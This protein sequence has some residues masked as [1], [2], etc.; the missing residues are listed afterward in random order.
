[1]D[2]TSKGNPRLAM[3]GGIFRFDDG[4][5]IKGYTHFI[6]EKS[7]NFFDEIIVVLEGI[8]LAMD[9]GYTTFMIN[10]DSLALV[11]MVQGSSLVPWRLDSTIMCN[12][13]FLSSYHVY[14]EVNQVANSLAD[15]DFG[16]WLVLF[17]H[18]FRT[19]LIASRA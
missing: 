4:T 3:A 14:R 17:F 12:K 9:M 18:P 5:F 19:S 1:M 8:L 15:L 6:G 13:Y 7:T 2:R 11:S 10:N 16:H